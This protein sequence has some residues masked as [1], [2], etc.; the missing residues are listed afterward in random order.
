MPEPPSGEILKILSMK[1]M[2]VSLRRALWA[3]PVSQSCC[4]LECSGGFAIKSMAFNQVARG[5][6][7]GSKTRSAL[8]ETPNAANSGHSTTTR[9]ERS[10]R[11]VCNFL[12]SSLDLV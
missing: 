2:V 9:I 3:S 6:S 1:S 11:T 8:K 12:N 5:Q 4:L 7:L 10:L